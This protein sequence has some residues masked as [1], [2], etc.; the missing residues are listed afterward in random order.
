MPTVPLSSSTANARILDEVISAIIARRRS[1]EPYCPTPYEVLKE[2]WLQQGGGEGMLAKWSSMARRVR[3]MERD[4]TFSIGEIKESMVRVLD[5]D[6][7]PTSERQK[8]GNVLLTGRR[9][10]VH[11]VL[12]LNQFQKSKRP[13]RVAGNVLCGKIKL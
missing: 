2:I 11:G 12:N 5:K 8:T 7:K 3:N 1:K 10:T 6:C 13:E 4:T 9:R